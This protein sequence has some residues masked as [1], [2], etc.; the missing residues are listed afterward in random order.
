MSP[1]GD[2]Q[3]VE[4]ERTVEFAR[5]L[6]N[7]RDRRGAMKISSRLDRLT[8]GYWGDARPVGRGLSELRVH[9]GP[10]YRIYIA[11]RGSTWVVVLCGGDKDSQAR[12]ISAAQRIWQ[13]LDHD[14]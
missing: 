8:E 12:D 13:E 11:Q 5:W 7:L 14:S 1:I 4:V 10:G 9:H 2:N 3:R 6:E